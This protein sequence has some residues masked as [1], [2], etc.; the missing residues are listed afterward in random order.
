MSILITVGFFFIF[1]SEA[2]EKGKHSDVYFPL[3]R[4]LLTYAYNSNIHIPNVDVLLNDEINW[5]KRVR[6]RYSDYLFL[7]F[8]LFYC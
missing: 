7:I 2:M 3:L 1:Q 5:L 4:R 6:V 8:R